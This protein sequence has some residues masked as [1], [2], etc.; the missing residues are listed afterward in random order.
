MLLTLRNFVWAGQGR[1]PNKY[2]NNLFFET[3]G[4]GKAFPAG[5][6]SKTWK[7]AYLAGVTFDSVSSFLAETLSR[8]EVTLQTHRA[9]LVTAAI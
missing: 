8:L 7:P 9:S 1:L 6:N 4:T 5:A 3:W 2:S